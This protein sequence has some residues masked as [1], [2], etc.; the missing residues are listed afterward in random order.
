MWPLS[1]YTGLWV[2]RPG[3]VEYL[4]HMAERFAQASP[5]EQIRMKDEAIQYRDVNI[6]D[7]EEARK[8]ANYYIRLMVSR[9][10]SATVFS[11]FQM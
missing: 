1:D 6:T 3:A 10:T 2:G 7:D 9:S 5:D 4:D 11:I 8:S